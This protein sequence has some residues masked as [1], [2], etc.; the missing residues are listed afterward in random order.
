MAGPAPDLLAELK[1][2]AAVDIA[3]QDKLDDFSYATQIQPSVSSPIYVPIGWHSGVQYFIKSCDIAIPQDDS[4]VEGNDRI[5]EASIPLRRTRLVKNDIPSETRNA[6]R[7]QGEQPK[8]RVDRRSTP[9]AYD[10]GHS[11]IDSEHM[12]FGSSDGVPLNGVSLESVDGGFL[13]TPFQWDRLQE[14]DLEYPSIFTGPSPGP[15]TS[16]K[17]DN[18]LYP[19]VSSFYLKSHSGST[20]G[21]LY[22]F[23]IGR[24][25]H[26]LPGAVWREDTGFY[27]ICN[28][29]DKS[30]WVA[31]DFEPDAETGDI[32]PVR[33][34]HGEAYGLLPNDDQNLVIGIQMLFDKGWT[35]RK[36]LMLDLGDPF[37]D[38]PHGPLPYRL[39]AR[40]ASKYDL[41]S[42]IQSSQ[43]GGAREVLT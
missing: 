42:A 21:L 32:Q 29:V 41:I 24:L 40:P 3:D 20:Q 18:S 36:P 7:A 12:F 11:S 22:G 33:P 27:V 28:A 23:C 17:A 35:A 5:M 4:L 14:V 25:Y 2:L 37:Q 34:E 39:V 31:F 30:I 15:S 19:G 16:S 9:K 1:A 26:K 13:A 38:A 8:G 43:A 10:F 6:V